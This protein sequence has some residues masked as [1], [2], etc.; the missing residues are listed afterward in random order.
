[1]N[2]TRDRK[3]VPNG[4]MDLPL[5]QVTTEWFQTPIHVFIVE[6]YLPAHNR[7]KGKRSV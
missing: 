5:S 1:M 7:A 6:L 4:C 3:V 2:S